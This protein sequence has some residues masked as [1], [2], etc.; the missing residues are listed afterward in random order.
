MGFD[1]EIK[2]TILKFHKPI[3]GLLIKAR[4]AV[5]YALDHQF[6]RA[7][8]IPER[9]LLESAIRFAIGN[10]RVTISGINRT[11]NQDKTII[12]SKDGDNVYCSTIEIVKEELAIVELVKQ[13]TGR[14]TPAYFQPPALSLEGEQ[15]SAIQHVLTTS[16]QVSIIMG[17]AGT[18]KT[19]L[20]QEA[21]AKFS[22]GGKSVLVVAP[23]AE[24]SRGVLRQEGFWDAETVAK[25]LADKTLQEKLTNQVL[26]VDE[27]GLVG[28]KDILALLR[29]AHARNA[30]LILSGDTKQHSSVARGDAL[31]LLEEVAGVKPVGLNTIRRQKHEQYRS[32]VEALSIGN[33]VKGYQTLATMGAIEEVDPEDTTSALVDQYVKL[34]KQKKSVLVISPTHSQCG[35]VTEAIRKTLKAENRIGKQDALVSQLISMNL[36]EAERTEKK[37]YQKGLVIRVNRNT[38]SLKAHSYGEVTKLNKDSIELTDKNGGLHNLPYE[39][40]KHAEVYRKSE[41]PLARGDK[42]RVTRNGK[43]KNNRRMNNGQELV[44]KSINRNGSI[45]AESET[46]KCRY[47]IGEEF[48][49]IQHAYCLTSHASQ[50]K[51]VDAVLVS[52]PIGTFAATDLKQFYVSASRGRFD[53]KIY[54]DDKEGLLEHVAVHKKRKSALELLNFKENSE[55]VARLLDCDAPYKRRSDSES[56]RPFC[57]FVLA[58]F[59]CNSI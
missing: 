29:L 7:S 56:F 23:T 47:F 20:M 8:V 49:H 35:V 17:R 18:G 22:E 9:K 4:H 28:T 21:V 42:V 57:D 33:A 40:L 10:P 54:T 13:T 53:L 15:A 30:Q 51:T 39:A 52:Q 37:S 11:L 50:G 25:L 14:N 12:K 24:A 59:C 19:S 41:L 38:E 36:T 16:D 43:D 45:V 26:W 48:R 3:W 58:V 31:R 6:E 34:I 1:L 32:A 44:V 46:T 27:A 55:A 2:N 5:G